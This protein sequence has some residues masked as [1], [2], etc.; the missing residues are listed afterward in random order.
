M[1][2]ANKVQ[3]GG[4]HYKTEYE[5]WDLVLVLGLG[6]LVGCCTKYVMR[7]RRKNGAEDLF[8]AEHYLQKLIE[9]YDEP[10]TR[11]LMTDDIAIEVDKFA[12]ANA[13]TPDEAGL[14]Y[15]LCTYEIVDDLERANL[16]LH[17]MMGPTGNVGPSCATRQEMLQPGTPEDGGHH[18]QD[19][20]ETGL[21]HRRG[22][23]STHHAG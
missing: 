21:S 14:T 8:K 12:A 6:Y 20:E 3:I 4:Q 7:A 15:L 2:N 13:L 5:H 11:K 1:P 22:T 17:R 23:T 10:P 19:Q 16:L 9:T 18:G